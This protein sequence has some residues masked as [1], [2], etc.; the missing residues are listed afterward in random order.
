MQQELL[1]T[2]QWQAVCRFLKDGIDEY[3]FQRSKYHSK[4]LIPQ[5]ELAKG[6][7]QILCNIAGDGRQGK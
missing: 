4:T 7:Y 1:T 2:E 6:A 3:Q 5:H